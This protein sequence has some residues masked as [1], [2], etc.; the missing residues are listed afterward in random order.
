MDRIQRQMQPGIITRDGFLGTESRR[1]ADILEEDDAAV[2]RLGLTHGAIAERLRALREAGAR[3]L[4]LPTPADPHFEVQVD[5]VR[6]VLPCPFLH[7]G[8]FPKTNVTVRNL[9][10]GREITYTDLNIHMIEAHGFYE[11][12]GAAFRLAPAALAEI[13]EL[14]PEGRP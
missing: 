8:V 4:G 10:S 3:G 11:G 14:A 5:S 12:Q 2:C 9:R 7:A 1:L 13:L 6:G